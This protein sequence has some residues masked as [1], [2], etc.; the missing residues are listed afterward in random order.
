MHG[1]TIKMTE[2]CYGLN[3]KSRVPLV[4]GISS[5]LNTGMPRYL[6]DTMCSLI[7]F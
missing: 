2:L 4:L 7:L 3:K 6:T 1:A 5:F